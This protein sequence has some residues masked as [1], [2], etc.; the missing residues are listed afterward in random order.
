MEKI[1][2]SRYGDKY[3]EPKNLEEWKYIF[4]DFLFRL[5]TYNEAQELLFFFSQQTSIIILETL[6]SSAA[7]IHL[8]FFI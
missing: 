2:F 5:Q 4:L 1:V 8:F 3:E 6:S 7:L